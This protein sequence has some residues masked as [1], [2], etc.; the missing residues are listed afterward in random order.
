MSDE[1]GGAVRYDR[2]K[3]LTGDVICAIGNFPNLTRL[4][5]MEFGLMIFI[6][7]MLEGIFVGLAC[8]VNEKKRKKNQRKIFLGWCKKCSATN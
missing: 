5:N 2:D 1:E 4:S 8:H 3:T 6:E 7:D